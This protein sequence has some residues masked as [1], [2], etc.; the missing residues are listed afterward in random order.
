MNVHFASSDLHELGALIDS[1]TASERADG[2]G[3]YDLHGSGEF[4]GK[5][6]GAV[7]DPHFEGLL[8][9]SNLQIEGTSWRTVQA[10]VGVDAH[11]FQ[12]HDGSLLGQAKERVHFDG[13]V[14]LANWSVDPAAPLSLHASIQNVS[15]AELQRL[16][17]T[18]YPVAGLLNG[19]LSLSGSER[20]PVGRGHV[21]LV[22]G[23]VWDE[24]V[25]ALTVDFDA[26]KQTVHANS[27]VRAP[28]GAS[29]RESYLRSGVATLPSAGPNAESKTGT[30]PHPAATPGFHWRTIDRRSLGKRDA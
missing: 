17:K 18:S 22:Q 8:A 15:A 3:A 27:T 19:E 13:G 10:R 6:S 21:E 2:I 9:A 23:S 12:I 11:S 5:V 29:D 4:T 25:N 20:S 1:V 30:D 16:G 28:A 7:K 26:D 24:P 14:K